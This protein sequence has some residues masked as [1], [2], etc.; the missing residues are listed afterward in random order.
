MSQGNK[1]I[2][3]RK[4]PAMKKEFLIRTGNLIQPAFF[5]EIPATNY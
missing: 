2:K 1:K 5:K 3:T 4:V